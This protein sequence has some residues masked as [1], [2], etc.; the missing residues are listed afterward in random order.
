M[1]LLR[2]EPAWESLKQY[3][4]PDWYRDAKLGIFIHWGVYAVPAFGNEWYPRNMYLQGKPEFEHHVK[5]YGPQPRFGYKDFVPQFKAEQWEPAAWIDL[6]G[7]AGARYIVPVA[8]H[9]D[10]FALYD[11]ALSDWNSV[12]RGPRRDI[13][14]ELAAATRRQG[15]AFGLSSHRIEHWWFMNGGRQFESDVQDPRYADFYGPARPCGEEW[16]SKDWQPRPDAQFLDDWLA[17]CCELVDKYQPQVFWFDWW[18]EQ[19]VAEPYRQ[20]FAAYYYNR[21]DEWQ[22]GVV[23]N[24]KNEAFPAG[25]AVLDIERGKLDAL[26][27]EYWQ[28]D[29][30]VSYKSWGYIEGDEFKTVTTL[31]HDLVDIVSKNGNLLLNVGPR[32]DGTL[33]AEAERLLLGLGDWLRVNGEAI[34]GTRPWHTFGEGETQVVGG[35]FGERQGAAFTASDIRFT[36]KDKALYAICLGWPGEYV[37]IKSLGAQSNLRAEQIAGVTLLGTDAPL[38]WAQDESGLRIT[39]PPTQPCEHACVFKIVL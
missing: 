7:R 11:C 30:S 3:R 4:V 12:R 17:R 36:T 28:T 33:P 29:T 25:T 6:F 2:F 23:L 39:L 9:H 8:E 35:A 38:A 31:V 24:Y 10:G 19:T 1:S 26:R 18:I 34:Y 32:A 14:G 21:A 20:K 27:A 37:I 5:T 15:L 16:Q 13:V 22:R